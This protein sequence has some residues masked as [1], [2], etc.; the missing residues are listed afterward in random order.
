KDTVNLMG[1]S[2]NKLDKS[3]ELL[4]KWDDRVDDFKEKAKKDIKNWTMSVSVV[5]FRADHA[6][7]YQ[8]GFEGSILT[9]LGFECPKNVK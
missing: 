1:E 5:N 7:I 2:L 9:E 8:T 6:S 3:K 4:T